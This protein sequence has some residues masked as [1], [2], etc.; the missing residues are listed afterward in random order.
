MGDEESSCLSEASTMKSSRSSLPSTLSSF[1]NSLLPS[2]L[3]P[4]DPPPFFFI[5]PKC[6]PFCL[7]IPHLFPSLSL[8][9]LLPSYIPAMCIPYLL[10]F[11]LNFCFLTFFYPIFLSYCTPSFHLSPFLLFILSSSL[12]SILLPFLTSNLASIRFLHVC[13]LCVLCFYFESTSTA[14]T[15]IRKLKCSGTHEAVKRL[16]MLWPTPPWSLA[17]R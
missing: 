12:S 11:F 5:L 3:L 2:I 16:E 1:L 8:P 17:C 14:L 7:L 9:S 10:P 15:L 4:S 13:F 6:L